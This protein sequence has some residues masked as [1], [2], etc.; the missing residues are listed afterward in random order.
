MSTRKRGKRDS[1]AQASTSR[2]AALAWFSRGVPSVPPDAGRILWE[3]LRGA[4]P[5]AE[6]PSQRIDTI[7]V[8]RIK[9]LRECLELQLA[10]ARGEWTP[11]SPRE[12]AV[13]DAA[14][15]LEPQLAHWPLRLRRVGGNERRRQPRRIMLRLLQRWVDGFCAPATAHKIALAAIAVGVDERCGQ[16]ADF[17]ERM[18]RWKGMLRRRVAHEP[19]VDRVIRLS[20]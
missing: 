7:D 17:E 13:L 10:E 4:V 16:P 12:R 9:L 8:L 15:A 18:E 20:V 5:R 2:E 11:A 19:Q 1:M 3:A 14:R 6:R